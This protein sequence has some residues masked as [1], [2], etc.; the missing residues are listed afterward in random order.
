MKT[1]ADISGFRRYELGQYAFNYDD[2]DASLGF[3]AGTIVR[4]LDEEGDYSVTELMVLLDRL[5]FELV[6]FDKKALQRLI[7]V[8]NRPTS[9]LTVKT[10]VQLA[11]DKIHALS[12]PREG[13]D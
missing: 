4:M 5:G 11:I 2:L 13:E 1:L 10:G 3:T 6:I 7:E 9:E 12:E 8:P